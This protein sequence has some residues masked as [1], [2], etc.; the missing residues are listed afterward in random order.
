[1]KMS[2]DSYFSQRGQALLI[3]VLIMV[4]G[5][6]VALSLAARTI[7]N[8]RITTEEE[9]SQRAFSAAE[10]G[11]ERVLETGTSIGGPGIDLGNSAFIKSA[12]INSLSGFEYLFKGG[13]IVFR[14]EGA[15][16]WLSTYSD[17]PALIYQ[18]PSFTGNITLFWGTAS[19]CNDAAIEVIVLS[20]P[21]NLPNIPVSKRYVFDP[22]FTRRLENGFDGNVGTGNY[23]VLGKPFQFSSTST[24]SITN[25]RIAKVIPLYA[26]TQIGVR[27]TSALPSQGKDITSTG[28]SGGTT[29][30]ITVFQGF[31]SLPVELFA[32]ILFQTQ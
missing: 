30:K 6:T 3:V 9:N 8:V 22:C 13:N 10:A 32:Y 7:T 31:P 25:G 4:V 29:R 26:N 15:D 23:S 21:I 1:M 2:K 19:A 14:D 12:T 27:A 18:D 20:G 5:L 24:I 16:L 28:V 17:D 11:I